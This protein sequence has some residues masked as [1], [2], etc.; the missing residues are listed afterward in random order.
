MNMRKLMVILV[1]LTALSASAF[2]DVICDSVIVCK[3][4][5]QIAILATSAGRRN[6]RW[7]E[8]TL[9]KGSAHGSSSFF[10]FLSLIGHVACPGIRD[11]TNYR[12]TVLAR[13]I[14]AH[15]SSLST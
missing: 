14:P 5:G 8:R 11:F 6:L 3:F 15:P 9:P 4:I 7:V 13:W 2:A 10:S 1:T 12:A